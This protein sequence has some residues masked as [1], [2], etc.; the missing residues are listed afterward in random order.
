M[1]SITGDPI[2][3]GRG[4]AVPTMTRRTASALIFAGRRRNLRRGV[5]ARY[6]HV[7]R[8]VVVPQMQALQASGQPANSAQPALENVLDPSPM[9]HTKLKHFKYAA[10]EGGGMPCSVSFQYGYPKMGL[11]EMGFPRTPV[12]MSWQFR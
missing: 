3:T 5:H 11:P 7:W 4:R 12:T 10:V 2:A 9:R 8:E 6:H 1:F